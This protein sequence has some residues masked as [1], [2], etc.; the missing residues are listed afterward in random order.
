M[1]AMTSPLPIPVGTLCVKIASTA[2]PQHVG[3]LCMVTGC[4]PPGHYYRDPDG[5]KVPLPFW[6]YT[7]E[8]DNQDLGATSP[9]GL[10]WSARA[11]QLRRLPP[12]PLSIT[13]LDETEAL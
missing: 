6:T 4:I 2:W 12:P 7:V 5:R 13:I 1:D 10:P 11:D 3:Q 9:A 8:F